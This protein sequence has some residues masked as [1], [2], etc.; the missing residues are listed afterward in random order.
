MT[1]R[2]KGLS[3]LYHLNQWPEFDRTDIDRA[4]ERPLVYLVM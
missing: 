4:L 1:L 3:V 2:K